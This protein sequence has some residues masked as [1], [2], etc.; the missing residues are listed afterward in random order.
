MKAQLN[1]KALLN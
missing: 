1:H